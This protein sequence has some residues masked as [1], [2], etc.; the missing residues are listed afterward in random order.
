MSKKIFAVMV[1]STIAMLFAQEPAPQPGRGGRGRGGDSAF[2]PTQAQWDGNAKTQEYVAKAK[3]IAGDDPDLRF[4]V[5]IFC[6]ASGGATNADRATIGV[7]DSLPH[8]NPYPSPSPAV[9]LGGQ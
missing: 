1:A 7:P 9:S 2:L 4:D 5:G 6:K 8:L 3:K